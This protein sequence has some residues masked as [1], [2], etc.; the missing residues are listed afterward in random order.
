MSRRAAKCAS[1]CCCCCEARY[2]GASIRSGPF[3]S[4]LVLMV[5]VMG[6]VENGKVCLFGEEIW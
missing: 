6:V 3:S 4:W 1:V 2:A 5:M